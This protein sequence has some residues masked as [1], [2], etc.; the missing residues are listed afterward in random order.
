MLWFIRR[1]GNKTALYVDAIEAPA[2]RN[3]NHIAMISAQLISNQCL[4]FV[5]LLL[6]RATHSD[7]KNFCG[8]NRLFGNL[9]NYCDAISHSAAVDADDGVTNGTRKRVWDDIRSLWRFFAS[10]HH[11]LGVWRIFYVCRHLCVWLIHK[12]LSV[13]ARQQWKVQLG[14]Y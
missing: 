9:K 2:N 5:C 4:V 8:C 7:C 3:A 14:I 10:P 13:C 11:H 6:I 1:T 12:C